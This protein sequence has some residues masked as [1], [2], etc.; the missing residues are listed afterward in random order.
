M[1][2]KSTLN[3]KLI[4][5]YVVVAYPLPPFIMGEVRPPPN[6]WD[7]P[8]DFPRCPARMPFQRDQRT[9]P[10]ELCTCVCSWIDLCNG[11]FCFVEGT[12]WWSVCVFAST[13]NMIWGWLIVC[14]GFG[15]GATSFFCC[16]YRWWWCMKYWLFCNFSKCFVNMVM[17]NVVRFVFMVCSVMVSGLVM[18]F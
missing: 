7:H 6:Y 12:V 8:C 9:N 2:P 10:T 13:C 18:S 1:G 11:C 3:Y 14:S 4:V 16:V 15:H 17:C 5:R